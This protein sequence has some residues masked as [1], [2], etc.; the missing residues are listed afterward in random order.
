MKLHFAD[1]FSCMILVH[2]QL[3]WNESLMFFVF[4]LIVG[5]CRFSLL[6]IEQRKVK[7]LRMTSLVFVAVSGK[8]S[9]SVSI[10][11]KI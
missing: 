7:T 4:F 3:C 6:E 1:T 8:T 2:C 9:K 5:M 10:G 11:S